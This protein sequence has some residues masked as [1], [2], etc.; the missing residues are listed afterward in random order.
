MCIYIHVYIYICI[1]MY[2]YTRIHVHIHVCI[3]ATLVVVFCPYMLHITYVR[4]CMSMCINL[5]LFNAP[6]T[7]WEAVEFAAEAGKP[8][9]ALWIERKSTCLPI[10]ILMGSGKSHVRPL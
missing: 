3:I 5:Q 9:A 7:S 4:M 1:C 6:S 8:T 10:G 2:S